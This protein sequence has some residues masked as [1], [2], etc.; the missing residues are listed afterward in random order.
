M[1][2]DKEQNKYEK[3]WRG[4]EQEDTKDSNGKQSISFIFRKFPGSQLCVCMCVLERD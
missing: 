1:T 3:T 2:V 4:N